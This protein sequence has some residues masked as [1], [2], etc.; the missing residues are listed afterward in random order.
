MLNVL[1]MCSGIFKSDIS[2]FQV[3]QELKNWDYSTVL[4]VLQYYSNNSYFGR[5]GGGMYGGGDSI[6]GLY[7]D[8]MNIPPNIFFQSR[9]FLRKFGIVLIFDA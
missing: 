9:I 2:H 4:H 5:L 1:L 6:L 3:L 8:M 7:D